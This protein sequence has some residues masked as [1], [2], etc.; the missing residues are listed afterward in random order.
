MSTSP[1]ARGRILVGASIILLALNL[2]VAVSSVGVV[3]DALQSDLRLSATAAGFLTTLPMIC[4]AVFGLATDAIVRRLGLH[5]TTVAALVAIASGIALRVLADGPW[6]FFTMSFLALSGAAIG[7]VV[8][9]PL[10]KVHFPDRIGL[11]SSLFGAA[12]MGG[13]TLG[14]VISVPVSHSGGGWRLALGM[15]AALSVVTLLPWLRMLR[16][17]VK[18]SLAASDDAL[19][20]RVVARSPLTWAMLVCFAAQSGGAY[21]QFGWFAAML[22]DGGVAP[23]T[24]GFMLAVLTAVGIPMTLALPWLIRR[25]GTTPALPLVFGLVT[26][27]GWLGVLFAPDTAPALWAVL[28]GLGG[29]AFSWVL[30]MVGYRTTS[31]AG[32]T[33][34]SAMTQGPGYLVG[35]IAPFG[36]GLLHDLT[37]SWTAPLIVLTTSAVMITIAGTF[38]ARSAPLESRLG[39]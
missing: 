1:S 16:H 6:L 33:A 20:L 5:R 15:W 7:N 4:F 34:L 24:A 35:A 36:T 3:M 22:S 2:R 21:T 12:L 8:L 37:G 14:S 29:G 10:V 18:N 17:D 11:L 19:P 27:A 13:A 25:W 26:V 30:A 9:P 39:K 28:L 32:T 23:D 31:A 38:I